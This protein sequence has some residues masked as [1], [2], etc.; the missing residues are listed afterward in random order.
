MRYVT[1]VERVFSGF[2]KAVEQKYSVSLT[3]VGE[4][5]GLPRMGYDDFARHEGVADALLVA[6]HDLEDIGLVKFPNVAHGNEL[7][8]LGRDVA[9]V[10]IRSIWA[11]IAGIALRPDEEAFVA[12]LYDQTRIEDPL[13]ASLG[14][15]DPNVI[16]AEI[17]PDLDDYAASLQRMSLI[18]DLN[19][20]GLI[21]QS[22]SGS[23]GRSY[24]PTYVGVVLV[25]EP[26]FRDRG[27][28]AGLIDWSV[29]TP[30]FELIEDRLA[31]LKTKLAIA[32]TSD[33]LS[34][35]GR[36]CRDLA[37]D[38][39]A[40][41]FRPEMVPD[42]EENP[43]PRDAKRQLDYYL[44]TRLQGEV[45]AAYRRFL[46]ASLELANARA[47]SDQTGLA[48]A[49]ASAQGLLSFLRA[50]EAIERSAS[51]PAVAGQSVEPRSSSLDSE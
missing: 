28:G 32:R 46:R 49:I 4:A 26:D 42:G 21:R 2:V 7:T 17:A 19:R 39:M 47:H 8:P 36:R 22:I 41:V 16:F 48:A 35:V 23:I 3:D 44:R 11:D 13:W 43:G 15:A 38:A 31:E 25:S 27:A 30:G 24:R 45:S 34:D 5:I 29:I 51:A 37:T 20:K 18:G 9:A 33:D 14:G 12:R 40:V 50:L 6:A 10:G 1:W